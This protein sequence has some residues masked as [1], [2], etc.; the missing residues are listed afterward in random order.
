MLQG[1]R[2]SQRPLSTKN[3]IH[4]IIKADHSALFSPSN[5]RLEKLIHQ[6]AY[7][8]HI[9][10]QKMAINW[11]HIHFVVKLK[12]RKDYVGFIRALTSLISQRVRKFKPDIKQIFTLRPFTRILH[13][14]RDL[15]NVFSYVEKNQMEAAGLSSRKKSKKKAAGEGKERTIRTK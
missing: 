2:K 10:I 3:P 12:D 5:Q 4:L 11:S 6:V 7:K 1:R 9:Q 15:T 8:F 14:G 13:Y